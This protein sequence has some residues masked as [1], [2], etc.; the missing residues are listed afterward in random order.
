[1]SNLTG[2][3]RETCIYPVIEEYLTEHGLCQIDI[4]N[5]LGITTAHI[6]GLLHG[7]HRWTL[8]MKRKMAKLMNKPIVYIF[9]E[10]VI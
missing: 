6:S 7:K 1:M 2:R 3:P 5:T 10:A 8:E 4:S 9:R